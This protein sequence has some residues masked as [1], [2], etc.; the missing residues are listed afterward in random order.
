MLGPFLSPSHVKL[1]TF[2]KKNR[3]IFDFL[4][5]NSITHVSTKNYE[6]KMSS[7][8]FTKLLLSAREEETIASVR[9]ALRV[10]HF[11]RSSS[12]FICSPQKGGM[13][14]WNSFFNRLDV[15]R[16]VVRLLKKVSEFPLYQ[17]AINWSN[18]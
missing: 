7:K 13:I 4:E 9:A 8:S 14:R 11:C 10:A 2:I 18:H 1:K 6:K 16:I 3:T 5:N 12:S 15:T 17:S